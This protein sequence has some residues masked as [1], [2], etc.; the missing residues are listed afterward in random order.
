M[1]ERKK[2]MNAVY[3]SLKV[4]SVALFF[5]ALAA[6]GKNDGNNNN[7]AAVNYGIVNGQCYNTT[8]NVQVAY[9]FC[10]GTGQ[11]QY[12]NGQ[13]I[14]TTNNTAVDPTYC[15]NSQYGQYG[16][17]GYNNGYYG[18]GYYNNGYYGSGYGYNGYAGYGYNGYAG[19][20]GYQTCYGSYSVTPGFAGG[21]I[22]CNG[23]NC[24][25]QFLYS[26]G[27]SVRVLCQ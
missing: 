3:Q 15:A 8:Q 20:G 17:N 4:M 9:T 12:V 24:R 19:Y 10:S 2:K 25:G 18:N 21:V 13:C 22:Y 26:S 27:S 5:L 1:S 16:Y 7:V 6:C 14:S 23:F 11:F